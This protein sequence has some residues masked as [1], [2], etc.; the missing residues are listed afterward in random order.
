MYDPWDNPAPIRHHPST[1]NVSTMWVDHAPDYGFRICAPC[2]CGQPE[3][4]HTL[5]VHADT[6][7]DWQRQEPFQPVYLAQIGKIQMIKEVRNATGLGLKE[8]KNLVDDCCSWAKT[9]HTFAKT[10][11]GIG[12]VKLRVQVTNLENF[13]DGKN[14]AISITH[15]DLQFHRD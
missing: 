13:P 9:R 10:Q 1:T 4:F 3:C 12:P 14:W 8:A 6:S 5:K 7:E 15:Q 2:S 11:Q